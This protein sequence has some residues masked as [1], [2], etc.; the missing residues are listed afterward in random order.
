MS[1][2]YWWRYQGETIEI[3]GILFYDEMDKVEEN[4][5]DTNKN[6]NGGGGSPLLLI[7]VGALLALGGA[8]GYKMYL[9]KWILCYLIVSKYK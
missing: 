4:E 5:D 7:C 3:R 1:W 8:Y 9:K 6:N 2:W